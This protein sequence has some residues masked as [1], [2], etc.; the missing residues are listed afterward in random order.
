MDKQVSRERYRQYI[1][2]YGEPSM[3]NRS[4][5]APAYDPYPEETLYPQPQP[6][7]RPKTQPQKRRRHPK[8]I[9]RE[10]TV[11]GVSGW[12]AASVLLF[13][14]GMISMAVFQAQIMDEQ[15]QIKNSGAALYSLT[16]AN[17]QLSADISNN[18][19]LATIEKIATE[20]LGMSKPN[21]S[22]IIH[23]SVPPSSYVEQCQP[24]QTD[25][26]DNSLWQK[27]TSL[28]AKLGL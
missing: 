12:V 17:N 13:F 26:S 6:R 2:N 20:K 8:I 15:A 19:N 21:P 14:L 22:Q 23:I 11:R 28:A 16:Q 24:P 1:S 18:Y 3:Y 25:V 10:E 7:P 4:A 5:T 27:I 9:R